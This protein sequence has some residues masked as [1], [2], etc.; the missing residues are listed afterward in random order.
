MTTKRIPLSSMP[1]WPMELDREQAAAYVGVSPNVF[2][3]EVK[4]GVWPEG[5][6][7]GGKGGKKTW[8]RLELEQLRV[9]RIPSLS[10]AST[11]DFEARRRAA[12]LSRGQPRSADAR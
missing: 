1:F 3:Q 12:R 6:S 11:D 8:N 5:W 9:A 7:R 4:D 10:E 2:D